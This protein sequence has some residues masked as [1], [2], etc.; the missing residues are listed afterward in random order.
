[1]GGWGWPSLNHH[2]QK[3]LLHLL[4]GASTAA[5]LHH[6]WEQGLG[7]SGICDG[8]W[9]TGSLPGPWVF[10]TSPRLPQ[11]LHPKVPGQGWERVERPRRMAAPERCVPAVRAN[12]P[13]KQ[14]W[15]LPL[16]RFKTRVSCQ[17]REMT[18]STHEI[19]H[20][21]PDVPQP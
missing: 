17:P 16:G 1:M 4:L 21:S 3:H 14:G 7:I 10:G 8:P 20:A 13:G 12:P 19:W 18:H 15:A 5:L 2:L 11:T 9:G 6:T